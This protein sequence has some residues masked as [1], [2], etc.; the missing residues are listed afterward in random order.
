MRGKPWRYM[1]ADTMLLKAQPKG[2]RKIREWTKGIWVKLPG[3]CL[4][5]VVIP[6]VKGEI[7][8]GD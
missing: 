8:N 5:G 3:N 2:G 1:G 4:D 6:V 7:P